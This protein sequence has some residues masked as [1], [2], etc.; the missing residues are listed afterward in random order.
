MQASGKLTNGTGEVF[1]QAKQAYFTFKNGT[2]VGVRQ[3]DPGRVTPD[4]ELLFNAVALAVG[5]PEVAVGVKAGGE[6]AVQGLKS[7]LGGE[8][9]AAQTRAEAPGYRFS[10][11]LIPRSLPAADGLPPPVVSAGHPPLP[12]VVG[13]H[14]YPVAV[15]PVPAVAADPSAYAP[16]V[17]AVASDLNAAFT[18][19]NPTTSMA[20]QVADLSTHHIPSPVDD[21]AKTDRVVLGRWDGM[22]GGYIGEAR[23]NGGIYFDTGD[24]TWN[25]VGHGLDEAQS[26]ALGWQVNEQ[27]LRTQLER[28]IGRID[29]VI[30][31]PRFSSLDDVVLANPNS[32]SALEIKFLYQNAEAYGYVQKGNSWIRV[33]G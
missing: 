12:A 11:D 32:F 19:G 17:P 16:H 28:G 30:D 26:K 4:D 18:A 3:L 15:D 14:P 33:K 6:A 10:D 21:L 7:L 8:G 5:A 29:Y 9:V 20:Q 1:D 31:S 25:A 22:D 2:L 23:H 27:F 24:D 13:E